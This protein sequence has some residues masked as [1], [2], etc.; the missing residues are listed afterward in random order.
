V[1]LWREK[2]E[3]LRAQGREEE[4]AEAERELRQLEA[5]AEERKEEPPYPFY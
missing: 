5:A 3:V 2:L 4:A 1:E